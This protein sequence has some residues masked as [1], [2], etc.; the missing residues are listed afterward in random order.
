MSEK[1]DSLE[2][3][4]QELLQKEGK[5]HQ[6]FVEQTRKEYDQLKKLP[7]K[8]N[9]LIIGKT[10]VGKS[11]LV[12][13]VFREKLAP[14]G[15]GDPVT[16]DLK[17]Y[18][19]QD[20][21][22]TIHDSPGLELASIDIPSD[23]VLAGD[24]AKVKKDIAQLITECQ[25]D[26]ENHIHLIWYCINNSSARLEAIEKSWI[27]ELE[28]QN[29]PIILVLTKSIKKDSDFEIYLREQAFRNDKLPIKKII[30]VLAIP[31]QLNDSYTIQAFGLDKLVEVSASFLT[32]GIRKI[33]IQEQIANIELTEKEALKYVISYAAV[34]GAAGLMPIPVIEIPIIL[35]IQASMA[36]HIIRLFGLPHDELFVQTILTTIA[37]A[38]GG[39]ATTN[40][41]SN[42][43]K[44]IPGFGSLIG[45]AMSV[46]TASS[47]T[48]AF[49]TALVKTIK[50]FRNKQVRGYELSNED[51]EDLISAFMAEYKAYLDGINGE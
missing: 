6:W 31:E 36:A 37:A 21:P 41:A 45:E 29:I 46:V 8:C 19:K 13:A 40:M 50:S 23:E 38:G 35:Q 11:S 44:T 26:P 18:R 20:C 3:I 9:I 22:I 17:Q 28:K 24:I 7:G 10:G 49:G 51:R 43:L 27:K 15:Q 2:Q 12:N 4:I 5:Y 14:T 30:S 39:L 48:S 1:K 47:F 42:L 34:A 33:F 16:Q 25:Q 32:E